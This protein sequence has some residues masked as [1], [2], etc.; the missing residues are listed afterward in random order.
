MHFLTDWSKF[1]FTFILVFSFKTSLAIILVDS[2]SDV[3][4]FKVKGLF[5]NNKDYLLGKEDANK[6][7]NGYKNAA[8]LTILSGTCLMLVS[9]VAGLTSAIVCSSTPPKLK[10]LNLPDTMMLQN[11]DYMAGYQR[12]AKKIKQRKVWTNWAIGFG[13]NVSV[14]GLILLAP[15]K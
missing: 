11:H 5:K 12:Q 4:V 10:N 7:Y 13:I 14:I 6:Y 15:G 2:S 9:P 8:T 1:L 3:S